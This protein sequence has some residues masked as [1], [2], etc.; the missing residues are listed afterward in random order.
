M[1]FVNT[2]ALRGSWVIGCVAVSDICLC[3]DSGIP[4]WKL[5]GKSSD[6]CSKHRQVRMQCKCV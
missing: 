4:S 1:M 6:W 2:G 5:G 3:D